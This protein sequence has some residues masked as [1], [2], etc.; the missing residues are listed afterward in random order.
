MKFD[1]ITYLKNNPLNEIEVG[2]EL[3]KGKEGTVYSHPEDSNKVI[4]KIENP[5]SD[6]YKNYKLMQDYPD[7]F[8]KIYEINEQEKYV[9]LEKLTSPLPGLKELQN[10]INKDLGII[11]KPGQNQNNRFAEDVVFALFEEVKQGD[12][13]DEVSKEIFSKLS[14]DKKSLFEK[15][16]N[17]LLN[18]QQILGNKIFNDF[19]DVNIDNIG[20]N[21]EGKLKIFDL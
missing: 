20:A 9:I 16:R 17:Y 5:R 13:P 12:G 8:A 14:G 6:T 2:S 18:S 19:N 21:E 7:V 3:G 4:K 10:F 11:Y 15:I 1:L